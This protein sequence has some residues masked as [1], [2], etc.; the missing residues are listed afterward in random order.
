MTIPL[1]YPIQSYPSLINCSANGSVISP[2]TTEYFQVISS[3]FEYVQTK[4]AWV[5]DADFVVFD[6]NID[7]RQKQINRSTRNARKYR[8]DLA[9]ESNS[10]V[11][12]Y[13][14]SGRFG[15]QKNKKNRWLNKSRSACSTSI[16]KRKRCC[17]LNHTSRYYVHTFLYAGLVLCF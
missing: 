16:E 9:E 5:A 11:A 1:L 15:K 7:F 12:S 14:K 4:L 10:N 2:L 3:G 17:A 6:K 13:E 8:A